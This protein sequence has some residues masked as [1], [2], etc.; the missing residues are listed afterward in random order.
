MIECEL[1]SGVAGDNGAFSDGYCHLTNYGEPWPTEYY[2]LCGRSNAHD[3]RVHKHTSAYRPD[4]VEGAV[5]QR[6][7]NRL[8]GD[9]GAVQPPPT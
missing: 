5:V 9:R 4:S 2:Q 8:T 3:K 1:F 6:L 7:T